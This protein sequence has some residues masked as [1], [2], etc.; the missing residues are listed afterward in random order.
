MGIVFG[1][2]ERSLKWVA[3][4]WGGWGET[5]EGEPQSETSTV[6]STPKTQNTP[7]LNLHDVLGDV[8]LHVRLHALETLSWVGAGPRVLPHDGVHLWSRVVA[9][10]KQKLKQWSAWSVNGDVTSEQTYKTS[11]DRPG[12]RY[13]TTIV[14]GIPKIAQNHNYPIFTISQGRNFS[15]FDKYVKIHEFIAAQNKK[16]AALP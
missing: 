1:V 2:Q 15:C 9:E 6:A 3:G 10:G 16:I 8:Q 7:H 14:P 12:T 5:S 11:S 4:G 13:C